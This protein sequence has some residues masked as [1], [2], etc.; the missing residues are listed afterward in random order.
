MR[1]PH[2]GQEPTCFGLK[3]FRIK[4]DIPIHFC[5][6]LRGHLLKAEPSRRAEGRLA[7]YGACGGRHKGE[8]Y[9]HSPVVW[10]NWGNEFLA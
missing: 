6:V 9:E 5:F 4:N 1:S 3:G 2:T 8:L 10:Q 7:K